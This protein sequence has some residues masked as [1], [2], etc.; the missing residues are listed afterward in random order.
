MKTLKNIATRILKL[1]YPLMNDYSLINKKLIYYIFWQKIIGINRRV[2]WPVH[3]SSI[4]ICPEKIIN[5][6]NEAP[7]Y[8]MN[9]YIDARN[10]IELGNKVYFGP[11]V[12]IISMNHDVND[13][14]KYI[15]TNSVKIG[16]FSWLGTSCIIL[17]GVE[18]GER[19]IVGAGA[20]VTRSFKDGNCIIA[21]NPAKIIRYLDKE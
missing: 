15:V 14:E 4:I 7:G 6:E 16:S 2:P 18:L 12:S 11:R 20:V 9:S 1:F 13:L 3:F 17:P 19:T 5:G 10:G 8:A 21:G